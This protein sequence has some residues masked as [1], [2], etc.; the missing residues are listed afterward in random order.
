[1]EFPKDYKVKTP[2]LI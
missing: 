1:V 2:L